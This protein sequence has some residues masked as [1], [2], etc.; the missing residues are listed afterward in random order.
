[1]LNRLQD[2]LGFNIPVLTLFRYP[3]P[4]LL[5]ATLDRMRESEIDA[6]A[7][8]LEKLSPDERDRLLRDLSVPVN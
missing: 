7:A 5:A 8:E 1:M 4:Q 3:T 6:L 2:S